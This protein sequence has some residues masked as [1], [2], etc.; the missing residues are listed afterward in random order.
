MMSDLQ[1]SLFVIGAVVVGAVCLYNWLQE[2]KL[3]SRL[4]QA[5]GGTRDDVLLGAGVD[6]AMADGR[7]EPQFVPAASATRGE[8]AEPPRSAAAEEAPAAAE[9]DAALDYVAE[10]DADA[11]F[12]DAALAELISKIASCGKPARIAALAPR[13]GGWEVVAHGAGGRYS[14]LRLGL[15]LVNRGG[16]VHA[17]QLA[18]FCDAVRHCAEKAGARATCPDAPAALNL[19][20]DIDAFCAKVDVA[21][22]VNIVARGDALFAGTRIR[23]QAEAAGFKLEPDGVFHF[24]NDQRQTLF[25]LDNHEPAPFLPE[26]IKSLSTRGI[27]LL[28]DVPRVTNS[29]DAL[30]RMLHIADGFTVALDGRLVDD[31]RAELSE[32]GIARIKQQVKSIQAA[33]AARDVPAGSARALRLFS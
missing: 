25:T 30:E 24:R 10:I 22:G 1:L 31:N 28:L 32:T 21:I 26:Q 23:A 19:A 20:R 15:Q 18:A 6:S 17:A 7:R 9:F 11:P 3:R 27:T 4:Q 5:F 33:M 14:R 12:T 16:P 2:R 29:D 13:S 8:E